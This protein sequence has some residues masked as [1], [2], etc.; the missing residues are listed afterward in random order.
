MI[1]MGLLLGPWEGVGQKNLDFEPKWHSISGLKKVSIF[2]AHPFQ[3]P[4][5]WICPHQNH[6]SAPYKHK[7]ILLPY[8]N[9]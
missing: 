8:T 9:P 1:L 3:W 2:R 5:K 7:K 6:F 4:S